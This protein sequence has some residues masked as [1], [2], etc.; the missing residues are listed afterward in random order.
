MNRVPARLLLLALAAILAFPA[1]SDAQMTRGAISGTV[2]DATGALVPGATVTATNVDTNIGRSTVT[3]A[4]GFY[5]IPALEPGTYHVKAELSG[6]QAVEWKSVKLVA[7]GEVTLN[8]ELKVAGL[9]EAIT[10]LGQ[11]EAI[12]LNKTNGT[13]GTAGSPARARSPPTAS[14]RATTTT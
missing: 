5:R 11:A 1:L 14:A 4:Q 10:V 2:R 12:E 3:D 6:F 9:G 7:A 13:V 8:P